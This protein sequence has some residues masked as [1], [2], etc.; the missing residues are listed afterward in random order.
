MVISSMK[1]ASS[2]DHSLSNL[3]T[4]TCSNP[5]ACLNKPDPREGQ[6]G[7]SEYK[8]ES[9]PPLICC[10]F[11]ASRTI[12]SS[13]MREKNSMSY[14]RMK[15][16]NFSLISFFILCTPFSLPYVSALFKM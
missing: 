16:I 7:R 13:C 3:K 9:K 6:E 11:Q 10:Q 1:G 8:C 5:M 15:T 12:I 2:L 14:G 4:E